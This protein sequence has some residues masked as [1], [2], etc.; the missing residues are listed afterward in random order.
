[1]NLLSREAFWIKDTTSGSAS[2]TIKSG[3]DP[4]STARRDGLRSLLSPIAGA[5][6]PAQV[7]RARHHNAPWALPDWFSKP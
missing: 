2:P 5:P 4:S 1:M 7:E 6:R 3:D